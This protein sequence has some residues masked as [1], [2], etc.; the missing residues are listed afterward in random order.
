MLRERKDAVP[1]REGHSVTKNRRMIFGDRG[2]VKRHDI[3]E[4]A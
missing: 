4:V 2:P 3:D 1:C